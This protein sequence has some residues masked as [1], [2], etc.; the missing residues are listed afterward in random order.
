MTI[1]GR[2]IEWLRRREPKC[3]DAPRIVRK[4]ERREREPQV[5][6]I[7]ETPP[8]HRRSRWARAA[9]SRQVDK[10]TARTFTAAVVLR[11]ATLARFEGLRA[12]PSFLARPAAG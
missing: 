2:L 4:G 1:L 3:D 10:C 9:T 5:D 6:Q 12:G 11:A 8:A 7:E